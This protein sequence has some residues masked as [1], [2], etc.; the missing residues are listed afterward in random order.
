[1]KLLKILFLLLF[2]VCAY[3]DGY[4]AINQDHNFVLG[5]G[6]GISLDIREPITGSWYYSPHF[7][8]ESVDGFGDKTS[9]MN[10]GYVFTPRLDVSVG[11]TYE[12]YSLYG[13]PPT[14]THDVHSTIRFKLW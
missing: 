12:K 3:S 11:A 6:A 10:I 13:A 5:D 9:S 14:E 4:L 2:P 8:F 1:M 7:S